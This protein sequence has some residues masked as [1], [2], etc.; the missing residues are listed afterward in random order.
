VTNWQSTIPL[1]ILT[2]HVGWTSTSVSG[3]YSGSGLI[4]NDNTGL[5]SALL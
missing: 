2:D 3:P 4:L 1:G 5:G